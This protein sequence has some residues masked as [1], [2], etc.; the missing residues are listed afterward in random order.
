MLDY[1]FAHARF[2]TFSAR[3]VY[4]FNFFSLMHQAL[5]SVTVR[6]II[7]LRTDRLQTDGLTDI[8]DH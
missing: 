1:Y 8:V 7:G 2:L 4:I 5:I 3:N 6:K